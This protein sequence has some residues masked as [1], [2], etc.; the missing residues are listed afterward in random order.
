MHAVHTAGV[1]AEPR[2]RELP[3]Q[4]LDAEEQEGAGEEGERR[5]GLICRGSATPLACRRCRSRLRQP[6]HEARASL[7]AHSPTSRVPP[8]WVTMAC[9]MES[10]SPEPCAFVVKKGSKMRSRSADR[11][12]GARCRP[13]SP[14]SPG[15]PL[16]RRAAPRPPR[17]VASSALSARLMSTCRSR[18]SSPGTRGDAARAPP[19]R[20]CTLRASAWLPSRSTTRRSSGST[21]TG[22]GWNSRGRANWRKSSRMWSSRRISSRTRPQRLEQRALLAL[23][24]LAHPPL[25][26]GQLQR[27]RVQR[28]A[29]LV[30]EARRHRPHRRQLLRHLGAPGQL[31]LLPVQPHLPHGLLQREQQLLGRARLHQVGARARPH[32]RHRRLQGGEAGEQHHLGVR[33]SPP[34]ARRPARCRPRPAGADPPAPRRSPPSRARGRPR[35][36]LGDAHLVA[37]VAQQLLE[38]V[39]EGRVVVHHEDARAAELR[40]GSWGGLRARRAHCSSARSSAAVS[41]GLAKTPATRLQR[42]H[43]RVGGDDEEGHAPG[44]ARAAGAA[45]RHP[46]RRAGA[47]PPAPRRAS[48]GRAAPSP[49]PSGPSRTRSPARAAPRSGCRASAGSSS[50]SATSPSRRALDSSPISAGTGTGL[51]S[52]ASSPSRRAASRSFSPG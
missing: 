41:K 18:S 30:G 40:G 46:G 34:S 20:A 17:G 2:Q 38:V 29:D 23:G 35:Q 39:E 3:H 48:P 33:A 15:R 26:H 12:S 27:R 44:S 13:P 19:P 5:N 9:T 32:R 43:L 6:Q 37:R 45:P 28:V 31:A 14:R 10:P 36:L 22:S 47:G 49:A 50:T 25:Q 42:R 16:P 4:R 24:Q 8:C 11:D 51:G 1:P 52:T 21:S 7:R